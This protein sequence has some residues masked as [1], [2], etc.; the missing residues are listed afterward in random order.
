[1]D[2]LTGRNPGHPLGCD[3]LFKDDD[4]CRLVDDT[5]KA[6][7]L[8]AGRVQ[9]PVSSDGGEP[10]VDQPDA[11]LRMQTAGQV[12]GPVA[13]VSGRA[14][15]ATAHAL[16]QTDDHL[17]GTVLIDEVNGLVEISTITVPPESYHRNG[18]NR[19]LIATSDTNTCLSDVEG[20]SHSGPEACRSRLG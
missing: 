15:A 10:F 8:Q 4:R 12:S 11:H 13:G 3:G 9:I 14:R 6:S 5:A 17:E 18:Q 20:E 7:L 16:G 19:V 1:M 2:S